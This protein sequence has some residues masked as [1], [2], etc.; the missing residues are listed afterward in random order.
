MNW[1]SL[2]DIPISVDT[3]FLSGLG[4]DH[5]RD[6]YVELHGGRTRKINCGLR[7]ILQVTTNLEHLTIIHISAVSRPF[8]PM[9]LNW[10]EALKGVTCPKLKSLG[11]HGSGG[12]TTPL[13]EFPKRY[14]NTLKSVALW[15]TILQSD[16]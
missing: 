7:R 8:S 1:E 3:I 14:G 15:F 12:E 10:G 11:L 2:R 13:V 4:W 5:L 16:P 9:K 6:L